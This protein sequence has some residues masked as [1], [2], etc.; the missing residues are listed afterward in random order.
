[1]TLDT[2]T[3]ADL[4][5]HRAIL[6]ARGTYTRSII[7]GQL[8]QQQRALDVVLETNYMETIRMMVAVGLGWSALPKSMLSNDLCEIPINELKMV[9]TLGLVQHA[10]RSVSNAS[11]AFIE[12][13]PI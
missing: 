1:L 4:A 8:V 13:L 9:R 7:E 6:P 2:V 11:A 3:L 10:Q 12:L 5:T